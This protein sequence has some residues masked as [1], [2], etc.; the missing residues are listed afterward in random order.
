[1]SGGKFKVRAFL[2]AFPRPLFQFLFAS[3]VSV[4]TL[5]LQEAALFPCELWEKKKKRLSFQLW[6]SDLKAPPGF[7][8][9]GLASDGSDAGGPR[10]SLCTASSAPTARASG[11]AAPRSGSGLGLA[12]LLPPW[13][14]LHSVETTPVCAV[15]QTA[16]GWGERWGPGDVLTPQGERVLEAVTPLQGAGVSTVSL[17]QGWGV[18]GRRG[19]GARGCSRD[20]PA[21]SLLCGPC[22]S[23]KERRH[24]CSDA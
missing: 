21:G 14:C 17:E 9:E 3:T 8:Q 2:S 16:G 18:L 13:W 23:R 10:G 20:I 22:R 24:F 4:Q 7:W 12:S 1:M 5:S 19:S 6:L 15:S 11:G